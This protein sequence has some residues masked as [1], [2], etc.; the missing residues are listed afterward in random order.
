M[1]NISVSLSEDLKQKIAAIAAKS[2]R[3]VD[4]CVMLALRDYVENYEDVYKTDL[5]AVD[6]LERSFF[7]SIGE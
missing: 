2:G 4:E 3:S 1:S 7:L 6:N 5:C